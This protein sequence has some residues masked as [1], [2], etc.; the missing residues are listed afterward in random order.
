[1][2][3]KKFSPF[4]PVVWLA[5][6]NIN[7][8]FLFYDIEYKLEGPALPLKK[9]YWKNRLFYPISPPGYSWV[10]PKNFSPFDPAVWPARGNI[11]MNVLFCYVERIYR[12]NF[13]LFV[14]MSDH[15]S[16]TTWSIWLGDLFAWFQNIKWKY[17]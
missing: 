12:S 14:C 15:N 6:G 17:W 13:Y 4:V 16:W 2:S 7:M 5:I 10:P 8:N 9:K 11:Y 1:M 3:T